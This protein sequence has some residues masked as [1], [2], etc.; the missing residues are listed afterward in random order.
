MALR[1]IKRYPTHSILNICG[2]AI[3]MACAIL[4]ILWVYDE[5]SY[6]RHFKN[7]AYLY[8]VIEKDETAGGS[9]MVPTPGALAQALKDEYP[10]I[11]R[12]SRFIPGVPLTLKKDDEYIFKK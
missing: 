4:I 11:I 8:R 1:N 6:D 2:M 3:G 5:W 10:E 12:A 7:A 9:M